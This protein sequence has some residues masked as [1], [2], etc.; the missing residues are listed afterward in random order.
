MVDNR[1][2]VV[3]LEKRKPRKEDDGQGTTQGRCQGEL[4]NE[5]VKNREERKR[6]GAEKRGNGKEKKKMVWEKT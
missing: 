2:H 3:Q 4:E 1:C 5:N 6:K